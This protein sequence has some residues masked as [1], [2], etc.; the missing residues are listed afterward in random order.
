VS[1]PR[2]LVTPSNTGC[3]EGSWWAKLGEVG[4]ATGFLFFFYVFIFLFSFFFFFLF[5]DS[6]IKSLFKFKVHSK[7]V[8]LSHVPLKH[9]M[10]ELI[11]FQYLFY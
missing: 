4:P 5:L 3:A 9:D 10:G 7:F 1:G 8:S 11:Y 6:K 2:R